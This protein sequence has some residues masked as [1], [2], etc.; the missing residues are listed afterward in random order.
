MSELFGRR[1]S[2]DINDNPFIEETEDRQFKMTFTILIDFGGS[3]TYADISI[4]NVS[5]QSFKSGDTITLRAGYVDT[6]DTLFIG[7]VQNV[8]KEREE[9]STITR[10]ICRSERVTTT[11]N[12]SYGAGVDVITLIKACSDATGYPTVIDDSQ[13]SDVPVYAGGYSLQGDPRVLLDKLARTHGFEHTVENGRRIILRNGYTRNTSPFVISQFT[14][15]EGIPQITEVGADVMMRLSPKLRIGGTIDIQS[16]LST[17]D[18]SN[19]YFQDIPESAG[20][21]IYRIQKIEHTGD[22]WGDAWTSK[23]TAYR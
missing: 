10:L 6:I 19:L 11:I 16:Q 4:Y 15:M 8:L 5:S 22:T 2:I 13:F 1:W 17:F 23:V 18:F 20:K 12:K 7:T 21:G 3:N 14:G 9:A